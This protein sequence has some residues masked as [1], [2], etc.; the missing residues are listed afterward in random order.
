LV[1]DKVR[2]DLLEKLT[3]A[4]NLERMAHHFDNNWCKMGY[5]RQQ[6]HFVDKP[7]VETLDP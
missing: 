4:A 1:E 5:A 3:R 7:W 6:L 2:Q